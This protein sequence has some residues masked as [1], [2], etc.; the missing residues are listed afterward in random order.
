MTVPSQPV[1]NRFSRAPI[2][3]ALRASLP[4]PVGVDPGFQAA[5][6]HVLDNTGSLIRPQL[7]VQIATAYGLDAARAERLAVALEHFHTASLIFDDLPCMDNAT[8]RRGA[9][10]AHLLYG[11]AGAILAA[12]ALINRAYA[13]TWRAVAGAPPEAQSRALA[14]LERSLGAEG[15]LNGQSLDLHYA[16]LPHTKETVETIAR[17]KTVSLIRLTL[18]LPAMLGDASAAELRLLERIALLWGLGYQTLDDLKDLLQDAAQTGK[19]PARDVAL[20]RPNLAATIGGDAAIARLARLIA[21]GGKAL[22]RIL[23]QRPGLEFLARLGGQLE[24]EL[25]AVMRSAGEPRE[26]VSA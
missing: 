23:A 3:A 9:A 14:Y 16:A 21:L 22:R 26:E 15:L 19:T 18:V 4:L 2:A 12:L 5:L 25:A 11:E 10:C 6:R 13:L 17:G 1:T 7:V 20:G 8:E 24:E